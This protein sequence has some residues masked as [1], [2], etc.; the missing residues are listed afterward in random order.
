MH[1]SVQPPLQELHLRRKALKKAPKEEHTEVNDYLQLLRG[2]RYTRG[3]W[4]AFH[5]PS[6]ACGQN[7]PITAVVFL[8]PQDGVN[9]VYLVIRMLFLAFFPLAELVFMVLLL[10][11]LALKAA[12]SAGLGV[13]ASHPSHLLNVAVWFPN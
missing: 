9:A 6:T 8:L 3:G 10:G 11:E 13:P 1:T 5:R 4:S 2:E 7:K 12:R